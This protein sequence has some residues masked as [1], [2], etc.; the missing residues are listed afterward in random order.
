MG[1]AMTAPSLH[2]SELHAW[3][4]RFQGGDLT[5]RDELLRGAGN[6]LE[7]LARK[8]FGGFPN[9]RGWVDTDDVLQN[10]LLRLFRALEEV[11]PASVRDFFGLAAEQM[12]RELLDLTRQMNRA[13]RVS[14]G[15]ATAPA[16][17][18]VESGD[19]GPGGIDDSDELE[20]WQRFHE[21]VFD[22]PAEE[23]EVVCL[24]FYHGWS[25]LQVA[26]LFVVNERTIRR[27]W[28]SACFHLQQVLHGRIPL[29]ADDEPC[30]A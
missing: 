14:K 22:L 7:R 18:N 17:T 27:R 28:R 1:N 9:L 16:D 10:S 30:D 6:R 23:R 26:D 12:R 2:T 8:M 24:V 3:V 5:A 25:H 15:S 19:D 13:Q 11:R 20:L 4:D 21:A 29:A